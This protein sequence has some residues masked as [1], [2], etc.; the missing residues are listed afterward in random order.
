MKCLKEI[1]SFLI[2][3]SSSFLNKLLHLSSTVIYWFSWIFHLF[4]CWGL[5][6]TLLSIVFWQFFLKKVLISVCI[7]SLL[8]A[9][10]CQTT[11]NKPNKTSVF[12]IYFFNIIWNVNKIAH[13]NKLKNGFYFWICTFEEDETQ[14]LGW[15]FK[16]IG[17]KFFLWMFSFEI[18][19]EH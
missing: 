2:Y 1:R 6:D 14:M 5:R 18:V 15:V 11:L 4:G 8:L 16:I 7:G 13:W 10:Q 12:C 9:L 19:K 17:I 3:R